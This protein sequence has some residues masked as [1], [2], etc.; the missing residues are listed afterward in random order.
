MSRIRGSNTKPEIEVRSMLHGCDTN[1]PCSL[2]ESDELRSYRQ[3][4]LA[5]GLYQLEAGEV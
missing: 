4:L 5:Y 2:K 3:S 1:D